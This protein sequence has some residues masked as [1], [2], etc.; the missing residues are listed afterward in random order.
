M[1]YHNLD[2]KIVY[3]VGVR[4]KFCLRTQVTLH[5]GLGPIFSQIVP[6]FDYFNPTYVL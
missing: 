1:A 5:I 2:E 3:V 4:F 6:Y